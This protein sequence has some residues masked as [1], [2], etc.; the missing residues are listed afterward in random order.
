MRPKFILTLLAIAEIFLAAWLVSPG[1]WHSRREPAMA[2]RMHA[3]PTPATTLAFQVEHD[4]TKTRQYVVCTLAVL[5]LLVIIVYGGLQQK[6]M[7]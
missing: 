7:D 3:A 2:V 1:L 4:K 6:R 5:N